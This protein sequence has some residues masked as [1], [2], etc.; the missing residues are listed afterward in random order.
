MKTA[1]QKLFLLGMFVIATLSFAIMAGHVNAQESPSAKADSASILK[2]DTEWDG[3]SVELTSVKR[4]EGDSILVQFK[5]TNT[6]SKDTKLVPAYEHDNIS[7]LVYYIDPKNKKKYTVIVDADKKPV[8]NSIVHATLEAG[9][10][11][12]GWAKLP[13]PP[14]DVTSITV[15][16]PGAPPFEKVMLATP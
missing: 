13:A 1:S 8:C 4:T 6:G 12:I 10:S 5:Y 3:V 15:F 9:A 7:S 2:Q 16:I 14:P 11:K